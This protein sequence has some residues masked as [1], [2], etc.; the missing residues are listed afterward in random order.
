[1]SKRVD[2][3]TLLDKIGK[4]NYGVV[5]KANHECKSGEFAIKV[6]PNTVVNSNAKV[7]EC[8]IN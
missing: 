3:Y 1:M 6:I 4:G 8:L 2:G 7:E 5:Y